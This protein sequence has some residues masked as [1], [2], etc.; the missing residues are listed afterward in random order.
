MHILLNTGQNLL[1][2]ALENYKGQN[3]SSLKK[4]TANNMARDEHGPEFGRF[5]NCMKF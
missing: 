2:S 4:K 3:N 1:K 5:L